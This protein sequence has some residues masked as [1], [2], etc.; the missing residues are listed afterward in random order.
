MFKKALFIFS[1]YLPFQL[2]TN[3]TDSLDLASVRLLIPLFFLCWL[4][5]GLYKKNLRIPTNPASL[6]LYSFI[7]LSFFS[8][9][10][11]E[12]ISWAI[13]K[14]LFLISIFPTYFIFQNAQKEK[15]TLNII[16][17]LVYGSF[18]VSVVGLIQFFSQFFFDLD[19][20]LAFWG[21]YI[22]PLFLGN[23]FSAA[24]L[25][26]PSWLVNISGQTLFRAISVFPDPH[27]FAYYLGMTAPLS[28][29][30]Y[31]Y[32]KRKM[33]FYLWA[34][35]II[36]I[37]LLLTFSRGG[38]MGF[39]VAVIFALSYILINSR[40]SFQIALKAIIVS[41]VL[42][43][44]LYS[45]NPLR[46]R[47]LAS[48]DFEEGSNRG[49]IELWEKTSS[50]I[51]ENPWGVGIGSLPLS[52]SPTATYRQPIYAHSLY[53]DIAAE[54]GIFAL[55]YFVT[56]LILFCIFLYR[57]AQNNFLHLAILSSLIFFAT[58]S[59]VETPIYSVHILTLLLILLSFS[60]PDEY[61]KNN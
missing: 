48:F 37:T 45:I 33:V 46:T 35:C 4:F 15:S 38:Y 13:R 44:L 14:I 60:N 29:A 18:A 49:R 10:F 59:I 42:A 58:Y 47:F 57:S 22:I 32:H 27:M 24:V 36:F 26:Y 2:A 54:M 55:F 19:K 43:G 25:E 41:L 6:F 1:I 16:E 5:L 21:T 50:V 11:A 9:F 8:L 52:I 34:F 61:S 20:I 3:P 12:N 40:Q 31:F 7:F 30:L 23:N 28:L 53:L 51:L 56:S 39:S 17:G